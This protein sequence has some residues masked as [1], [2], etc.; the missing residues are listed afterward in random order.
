MHKV[1]NEGKRRADYNTKILYQAKRRQ[2]GVGAKGGQ[3]PWSV[4]GSSRDIVIHV[5]GGATE[6]FR[7][8]SRR[9]I[10][11]ERWTSA[12]IRAVAPIGGGTAGEYGD[13]ANIGRMESCNV[14]ALQLM[15]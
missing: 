13:R 3:D 7:P 9:E 1:G 10:R 11:A 6:G 15:W 2:W 12:E 4:S 5:H 8:S 14:K